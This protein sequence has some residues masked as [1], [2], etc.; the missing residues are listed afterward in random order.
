MIQSFVGCLNH[1]WI[2]IL[3]INGSKIIYIYTQ[4]YTYFLFSEWIHNLFQ[5]THEIE[6]CMSVLWNVYGRH[7]GCDM[8]K[9]NNCRS[10]KYSNHNYIVLKILKHIIIYIY[11]IITDQLQM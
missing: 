11:S 2:N 10:H 7:V 9:N 8:G 3:W 4:L 6:H 1:L 5:V